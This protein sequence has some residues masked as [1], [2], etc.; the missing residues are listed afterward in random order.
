MRVRNGHYTFVLKSLFARK[1]DP[2]TNGHPFH[3]KNINIVYGVP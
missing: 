2:K 3:F 1:F